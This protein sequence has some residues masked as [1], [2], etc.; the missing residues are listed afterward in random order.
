MYQLFYVL[1]RAP[2]AHIYFRER[3]SFNPSHCYVYGIFNWLNIISYQDIYFNIISLIDIFFI[4][5]E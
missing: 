4:L 2:R 5:A 1:E 3:D